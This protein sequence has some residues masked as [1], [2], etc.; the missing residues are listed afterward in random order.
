MFPFPLNLHGFAIGHNHYTI[1]IVHDC[2]SF[3]C[4]SHYCMPCVCMSFVCM[5]C[6]CI[7]FVCMPCVCMSFVCRVFV[8]SLCYVYAGC[9]QAYD[10]FLTVNLFVYF[11][12]LVSFYPIIVDFIRLSFFF[13]SRVQIYSSR[14]T[15]KVS[16][17]LS[18][19]NLI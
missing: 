5:P 1:S 6:V 12:T 14:N 3:V 16:L 10:S 11:L 18:F 8:C 9:L 15:F 4:M 2:M 7:S 17:V 19:I 13:L